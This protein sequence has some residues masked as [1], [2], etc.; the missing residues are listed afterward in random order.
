MESGLP[1]VNGGAVKPDDLNRD[2]I[3]LLVLWH[4]VE[5]S[6]ALS[7]LGF[8][9][10]CPSCKS[11]RTSRQYDDLNGAMETDARGQ[12]ARQVGIIVDGL[13]EPYRTALYV[14]ARN[15]ATGA[16]VWMSPRL[17]TDEMQRGLL[18]AEALARFGEKV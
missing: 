8:P 14:L 10:E 4:N 17:P 2:L 9:K 12:L 3:G 18:V 16:R 7:A 11:Y 5:Q 13:P 15:R 1:R 6:G